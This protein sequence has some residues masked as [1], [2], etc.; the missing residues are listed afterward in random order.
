MKNAETNIHGSKVPNNEI[1]NKE[2][3]KSSNIIS[4]RSA[5]VNNENSIN[6]NAGVNTIANG[7]FILINYFSF[8]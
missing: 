2:N 3:D 8:K 4:L 1:D 7:N 5:K 6:I